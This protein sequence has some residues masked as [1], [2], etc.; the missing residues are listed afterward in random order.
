MRTIAIAAISFMG[1]PALRDGSTPGVCISAAIVGTA[2]VATVEVGTRG[3]GTAGIGTNGVGIAG[4]A[5]AGV[6][7]AGV[8]T[9]GVAYTGAEATGAGASDP[10]QAFC[11]AS[12]KS[13]Q[14]G[15]R[16]CGFLENTLANTTST[17]FGRAGLCWRAGSGSKV[18]IRAMTCV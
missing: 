16:S 17:S 3:V 14:L 18:I 6:S 2:G 9:A 12:A 4:V 1:G 15:N 5:A 11:K 10:R 8:G 7:T 13:Q